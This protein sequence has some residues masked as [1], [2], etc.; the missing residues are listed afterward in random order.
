MARRPTEAVFRWLKKKVAPRA[1]KAAP[2]PPLPGW[3]PDIVQPLERVIE[4]LRF[5]SEGK[6]DLAFF[7]HGTVVLLPDGLDEAAAQAFAREALLAIFHRHRD[8]DPE[9]M[10]DGNI[11]VR[12]GERV[13]NLVLGDIAALHRDAIDAN[14]LRALAPGEVLL[15]AQG[16]NIFDDFGKRA[17]FGRCYLF[18]DGQA[19]E[20][21]R[22]VRADNL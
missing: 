11:L 15:T 6:R 10:K 3:R 14:H 8:M 2:L 13:A 16:A 22:I 7:A 9:Q 4:R 21:V 1:A 12:Y 5:Y 20:I 18:M 17:L 19:P